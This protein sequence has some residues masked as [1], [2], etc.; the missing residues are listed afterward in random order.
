MKDT[1]TTEYLENFKKMEL[2]SDVKLQ[3]REKL[4]AYADFHA[5][6]VGEV[7]RSIGEVQKHSVFSFFINS[8]L[9]IMN[10]TLLIALIVATSG[11]SF[12][13]QGSVPGEFLYPVKVYV[14]ENVQSTFAFGA[15][16]E[17]KLQA[18]LLA[19]RFEEA[20]VLAERGELEG[21]V[22]E[23]VQANMQAQYEKSR[24][25]LASA[26]TQTN[27]EVSADIANTV[28]LY[29][30]DVQ[31]SDAFL[32][33][34]ITNFGQ[35]DIAMQM[36]AS[37]DTQSDQGD[38]TSLSMKMMADVKAETLIESAEVR[39]AGLTKTIKNAVELGAS[40]KA[41]FET[42]LKVAVKHVVD[43]QA[44]VRANAEA[45]AKASAEKAHEILG[46]IESNLSL[47]GEVEIDPETGS[48]INIRI[49]GDTETPIIPGST[50]GSGG[51]LN[52]GGGVTGGS[53]GGDVACTMDA[54]ICPDGSAVG[55]G[56]PN[57]TFPACPTSPETNGGNCP[58][59]AKICPDGTSVVRQGPSCQFAP[60]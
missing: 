57:C 53:G 17:A 35:S 41:Q 2:S 16:A 8:K 4:S 31:V 32:A 45:E 25:A 37:S 58:M 30:S 51:W 55:R 52:I 3:M 22:K 19:E 42:D 1:K 39:I 28:A 56:G 29:T 5:V 44:S 27:T 40:V 54:K 60:C 34:G 33:S 26:D 48:I 6:R 43:A 14:N 49:F 47:L 21:E 23:E 7:E 10:A 18:K 13:A 59:D 20:Q 38:T 15:N 24:L 36:S 9:R 46:K 12:A 50:G 11:T